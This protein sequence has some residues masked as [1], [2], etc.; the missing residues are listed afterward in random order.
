MGMHS[1]TPLSGSPRTHQWS[2]AN[3]Y[4]RDSTSHHISDRVQLGS[5]PQCVL[6]SRAS[7]GEFEVNFKSKL[8]RPDQILAQSHVEIAV[9]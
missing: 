5:E 7:W 2:P 1:P 9:R 8:S 3:P 6:R 4:H